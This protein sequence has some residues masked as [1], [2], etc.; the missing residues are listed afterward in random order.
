MHAIRVRCRLFARY[1]EV[2]GEEEVEVEVPAPATVADAIA[3]LRAQ[4][5]EGARL[6]PH[7]LVA[8]NRAHALPTDPIADGDELALLPPLA[9]G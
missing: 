3:A 9:G 8:R 4:L 7:P 6:P 2:T 5:A 1:A